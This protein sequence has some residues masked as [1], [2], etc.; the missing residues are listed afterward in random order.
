[1]QY[2]RNGL[3]SHS[4]A[5]ILLFF[6]FFLQYSDNFVSLRSCAFFCFLFF[7]FCFFQVYY[8][9]FK[10]LNWSIY[11]MLSRRSKRVIFC[12]KYLYVEKYS[13]HY[14]SFSVVW[15]CPLCLLSFSI[16]SI[17]P[18]FSSVYLKSFIHYDLIHFIP[19]LDE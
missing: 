17:A 11:I 2:W 18:E 5:S 6:F 10:Q 19:D 15:L 7:V 16:F 3:L 1:M 4:P 9:P 8:F 13:M 14:L 12:D